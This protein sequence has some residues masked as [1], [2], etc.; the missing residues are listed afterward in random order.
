MAA[1]HHSVGTRGTRVVSRPVVFGE[2]PQLFGMLTLPAGAV[3]TRGVV[4]CAPF[5]QEGTHSYRPLRTLAQRIAA[6]GSPVLRFDWPGS[7]DSGDREAPVETAAGWT[8]P[9]CEAVAALR[10]N[11]DV[12]EVALVGLRVGATIALLAALEDGAVSE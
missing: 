11:A 4:V 8:Q 2:S 12:D 7:G 1:R 5:G 3:G 9:V 6:D 10:A